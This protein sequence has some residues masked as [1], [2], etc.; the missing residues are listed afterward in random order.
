VGKVN[1][2]LW[3]AVL[4]RRRRVRL[5]KPERA[6]R[7]RVGAGPVQP[8]RRRALPVRIE[9]PAE[10]AGQLIRQLRI[11]LVEQ[12]EQDVHVAFSRR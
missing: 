2:K 10:E 7:L 1:Y 9:N 11:A 12:I 4:R 6:P 5:A 3:V 8:G